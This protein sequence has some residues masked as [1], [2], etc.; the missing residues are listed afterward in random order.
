M[1]TRRSISCL[2]TF[3]FVIFNGCSP[4]S[5][6]VKTNIDGVEKNWMDFDSGRIRFSPKTKLLSAIYIETEINVYSKAK[7]QLYP[8][9]LGISL[10]G[11]D[12]SC[13]VYD[14]SG[15]ISS[16]QSINENFTSFTIDCYFDQVFFNLHDTIYLSTSGFIYSNNKQIE[17]S[18]ICFVIDSVM[19]RW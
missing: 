17:L 2:F 1:D 18:D 4:P 10:N 16:G 15:I 7:F 13:S 19:V 9:S 6:L 5:A 14:S 3:L 8:D 12:Y 11:N